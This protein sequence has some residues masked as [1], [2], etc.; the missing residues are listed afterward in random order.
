[1]TLKVDSAFNRNEY[2]KYL[3]GGK[4]GRCIGL[5]TLLLSCADCLKIWEP[6]PPGNLSLSRPVM[7]MLAY[8]IDT[9]GAHYN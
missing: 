2:Q 8:T 4:S 6:H 5:T 1:M 7:E 3:L 9:F